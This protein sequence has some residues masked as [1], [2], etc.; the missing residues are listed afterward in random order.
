VLGAL[1]GGMAFAKLKALPRQDPARTIDT[2]VDR[3][4]TLID[5]FHPAE[6]ANFF[7]AADY[8]RPR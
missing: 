6:C 1:D 4:G 5:R 8:Q 3:I 7:H 2:F